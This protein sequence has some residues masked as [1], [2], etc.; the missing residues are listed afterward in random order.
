MSGVLAF[1]RYEVLSQVSEKE[2]LA[3]VHFEK[4]KVL[5]RPPLLTPMT[6]LD[7]LR[8]L[9]RDINISDMIARELHWTTLP[10][11]AWFQEKGPFCKSGYT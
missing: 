6:I 11:F 10:I 1:R 4:L 9:D 8:Y 5:K 7:K 2:I 3:Y